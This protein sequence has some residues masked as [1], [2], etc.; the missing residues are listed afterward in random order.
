MLMFSLFDLF[1]ALPERLFKDIAASGCAKHFKSFVEVNVS[2]IPYESQVGARLFKAL[3]A[4]LDFLAEFWLLWPKC[5]SE[6]VK[7]Y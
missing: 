2:F 5:D 3:Q 4:D 1:S 7:T 6:H